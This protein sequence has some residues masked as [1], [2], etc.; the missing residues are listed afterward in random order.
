MLVGV[1]RLAERRER[2]DAGA[3]ERGRDLARDHREA[4]HD[5][6]VALGCLERVLEVVERGQQ[7]LGELAPRP[8]STAAAF[9]RAMR[10][11]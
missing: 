10:L 2:L 11:R 7:L 4:L 5:I 3:V 6:L 8:R 9:S 1:E